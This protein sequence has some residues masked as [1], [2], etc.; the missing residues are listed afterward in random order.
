MYQFHTMHVSLTDLCLLGLTC[1]IILLRVLVVYSTRSLF[2]FIVEIII[3]PAP[4]V[5]KVIIVLSKNPLGKSN[6][7]PV[8]IFNASMAIPIVI[9]NT[10]SANIR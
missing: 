2:H 4:I 8:D 10:P 7:Y 5:A 3:I 1:P 9:K 6:A